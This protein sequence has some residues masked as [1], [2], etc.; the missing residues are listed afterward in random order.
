MYNMR[1]DVVDVQNQNN[2]FNTDMYNMQNDFNNVK[3]QGFSSI[4]FLT[5]QLNSLKK[6]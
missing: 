2:I 1:N 5:N 4:Q 3:E 6:K